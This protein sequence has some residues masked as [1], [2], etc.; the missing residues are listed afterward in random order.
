M[1]FPSDELVVVIES[2]IAGEAPGSQAIA[3]R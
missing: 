1:Q 3:R 2:K